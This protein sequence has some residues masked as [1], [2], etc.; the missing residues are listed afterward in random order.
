MIA[1]QPERRPLDMVERPA[2]KDERRAGTIDLLPD[3]P[4]GLPI[5]IKIL[6]GEGERTRDMAVGLALGVGH[7]LGRKRVGIIIPGTRQAVFAIFRH[8]HPRVGL[9]IGTAVVEVTLERYV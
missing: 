4:G 7:G 3:L 8:Q 2:R 5:R 1:E 6:D 9:E